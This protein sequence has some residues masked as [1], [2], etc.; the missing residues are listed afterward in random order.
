MTMLHATVSPGAELVLPWPAE[1]NALAYVLAGAGSVGA[2][3]HPVRMGQLAVFGDGDVLTIGAGPAQPEDSPNLEVL[4]LGGRPIREPIAH[5]G[6]FL[7]NNRAEILQ[8]IE[9]YQAGRLGVIPA[10]EATT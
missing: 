9:D 5:Y 2:E 6:P 4:I 8:A 10:A 3:Q 1:F 7:M